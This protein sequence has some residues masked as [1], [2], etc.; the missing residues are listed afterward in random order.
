MAY[1]DLSAQKSTAAL[2]LKLE[3]VVVADAKL[4]FFSVFLSAA[5][6]ASLVSLRG[7]VKELTSESDH[8]RCPGPPAH[9]LYSAALPPSSLSHSGLLCSFRLV[10]QWNQHKLLIRS[11]SV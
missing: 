3:A 2:Q 1:F 9:R 7:M 4:R 10:T 11:R 6:E 5:P 8:I